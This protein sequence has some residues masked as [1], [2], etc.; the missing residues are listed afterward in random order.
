MSRILL[1]SLRRAGTPIPTNDIWIAAS[2]MQHGSTLLST[3]PH[4]RAVKQIVA[5][6]LNVR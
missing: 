1:D 4:F 6:I 2:T 3:D 5:E